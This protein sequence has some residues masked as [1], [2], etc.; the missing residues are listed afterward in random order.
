MRKYV[1][2]YITKN[3]SH[4]KKV[5]F[6]KDEILSEKSIFSWQLILDRNLLK[7]LSR[8]W[9]LD[10]HVLLEGSKFEVLPNH[11]LTPTLHVYPKQKQKKVY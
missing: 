9:A 3:S 5:R 7:F 10:N 2:Y 4:V 6:A 8:L 1:R 11:G